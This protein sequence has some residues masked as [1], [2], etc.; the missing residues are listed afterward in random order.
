[1]AFCGNN[2]CKTPTW[3]KHVGMAKA[4]SEGEQE[5]VRSEV[6][7]AHIKL[8][9]LYKERHWLESLEQK[10]NLIRVRV[11]NNSSGCCSENRL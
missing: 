2:N 11:L 8:I 5:K 4:V 7:G 10:S 1:M 6:L 3:N 9:N